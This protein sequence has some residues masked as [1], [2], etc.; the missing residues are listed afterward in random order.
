MPYFHLLPFVTSKKYGEG[1]MIRVVI[2]V[3]VLSFFYIFILDL[4]FSL[5][6]YVEHSQ[7]LFSL[8]PSFFFPLTLIIIYLVEPFVFFPYMLE[9]LKVYINSGLRHCIETF[10]VVMTVDH[11]G[12]VAQ[13]NIEFT[14][15]LKKVRL[16]KVIFSIFFL[17]M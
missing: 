6:N 15:I 4:P 14:R 2:F 16:T 17:C 8:S 3:L 10:V 12:C 5:W 13:A 7:P 11:M 1:E 9:S